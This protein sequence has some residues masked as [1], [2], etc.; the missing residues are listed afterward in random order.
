MGSPG[1]LLG[2]HFE[3]VCDFSII[4]E[5]KRRG[6]EKVP[7]PLWFIQVTVFFPGSEYF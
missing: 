1:D 3:Q 2:F 7:G 5:R 6:V 4:P